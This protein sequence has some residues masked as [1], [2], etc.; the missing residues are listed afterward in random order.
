MAE[1]G[2]DIVENQPRTDAEKRTIEVSLLVIRVRALLAL[3]DHAEPRTEYQ[4]DHQAT[5]LVRSK[6][7]GM[8]TFAFIIL[9]RNYSPLSQYSNTFHV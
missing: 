3:G 7:E 8:S 9:A 1:I 5:F 6:D 2:I 4:V